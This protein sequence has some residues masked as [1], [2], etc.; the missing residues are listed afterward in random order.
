MTELAYSYDDKG[1][2]KETDITV[3]PNG[4]KY[5]FFWAGPY[6]NWHN[7]PFNHEGT[8][9]NC[10]EQFMMQQKALR[11]GDTE[12]AY[13]VMA[14]MTP[15]VQKAL[16]RQVRGFDVSTWQ[17]E[18]IDIMVPALVSKFTATPRLKQLILDSGDAT[19]V[20]ASPYDTVWGVGLSAD[21]E[22]ILD[23]AQWRGKN[24]LGIALMRARDIIKG[25]E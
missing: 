20:E 12:I 25:M 18:A 3:A 21:D 11:F 19:L 24:F 8:T 5:V 4:K 14:A 2:Y 16:G 10:S 22:R 17:A 1:D 23:E 13:E 15:G 7:Q 6:S 9:Y